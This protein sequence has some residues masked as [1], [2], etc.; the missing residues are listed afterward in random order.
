M[1]TC[2]PMPPEP[3]P[4]P[5]QI[6]L[7]GIDAVHE[8]GYTVN[9]QSGTEEYLFEYF[10][11][12]VVLEDQNER[13]EHAGSVFIVYAPGRRQYFRADTPLTHTWFQFSGTGA[14]RLLEQYRIPLNQAVERASLDFLAPLLEEARRQMV[15]RHR[16]WE[17]AVSEICRS[18]FRHLSRSLFQP[19]PV[20]LSPVQQQVLATLHTVRAQVYKDL[21]R[22]WTVDDMADL[23]AMS[24]P[25]FAVAYRS[26]FGT[27]PIDDL[28]DVRLRHAEVLLQH[29]PLSVQDAAQ[30]SGFN[31]AS[32][33][34]VRFRERLGR[35][36]TGIRR[37]R[38]RSMPSAFD[39]ENLFESSEIARRINLLYLSPVGH[40]SFDQETV[41]VL[42]D[43]GKHPPAVLHHHIEF[44]AGRTGGHALALDGA[45]HAVIPEVVV[46]T[47]ASYT[48][49]GWLLHHTEERMTA[50]SVGNAHHG[51]FYLQYIPEEG[52]F[53]FAVT[54]SARDPLAIGA[55]NTEPSPPDR[56][57][58]VTGVHDKA[59]EEIRLY[60]DGIMMASAVYRIPWRADGATYFGCSQVLD[61]V[62]DYWNG[63]LDD[64]RIYDR[65]LTDDEVAVLCDDA[66]RD[67]PV[68]I[69][70]V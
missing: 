33:F 45:S 43:L 37:T 65:A 17:D 61:T 68:F 25:R 54:V 50:V 2:T 8:A 15:R 70:E 14:A 1:D 62:I 40:W 60:V 69:E 12:P 6:S 19:G 53:K 3:Y 18:I 24:A 42:D 64:I 9:R 4:D 47:S 41:C 26:H 39:V 28:I 63:A 20:A 52:G 48:V 23:A 49:S 30:L 11:S 55:V 13:L 22:R 32:N 57:Y 10:E 51:A 46:D 27:G 16:H 58:H 38:D 59:R 66:L 29:L 31:T 5:I 67:E 35:S 21:T 7:M 34:H 56:W 44:M 36:P